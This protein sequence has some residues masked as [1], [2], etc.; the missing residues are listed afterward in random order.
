VFLAIAVD[1]LADAE[2]LSEIEAENEREKQRTRSLRRS[3]T[4][5]ADGRMAPVRVH[6][7][8]RP[9][10]RRNHPSEQWAGQTVSLVRQHD[11]PTTILKVERKSSQVEREE[12]NFVHPC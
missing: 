11:G 2:N 9:Y 6:T 4:M 10:T 7:C 8:S 12:I 5:R 1:N 3:S